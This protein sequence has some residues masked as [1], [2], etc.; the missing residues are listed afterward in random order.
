[1]II[2]EMLRMSLII[3]CFCTAADPKSSL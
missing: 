1:M 3:I 2:E